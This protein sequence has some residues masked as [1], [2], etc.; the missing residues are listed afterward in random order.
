MNQTSFPI[1]GLASLRKHAA[2]LD[3]AQGTI[4]FPKIQITM[5]LTDEMQK[6]NLK[7][8][9]TKTEAKHTTPAHSTRTI[10]A[11]IPVSTEHPITG[12]IQLLPQFDECAK[13]IVAPAITTARDKKVPI[14]IANTTD[15]PK[16]I[17]K[18]TKVA[19]L[20]LLKPE[21]TKMIRPVN[22]AALNLLTEHLD[23]VTYINALMQVERPVDNEEKFWFSPLKTLE[24][25]RNI[26]HSKTK[27]EGTTGTGRA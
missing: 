19:E 1:I 6:C 27:P 22:I 26:Q 25:S 5:A 15:F 21:E 13:L 16:T 18:D 10:Y 7:P 11:S 20:Q 4:D 2:I 14:K 12:T 17:A 3:T 24:M 23:V 9:T 8:N